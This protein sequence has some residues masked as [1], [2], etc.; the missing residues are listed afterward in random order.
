MDRP[1]S[2]KVQLSYIFS[3]RAY[4]KSVLFAKGLIYYTLPFVTH[5][6][7]RD[8]VVL[9]VG[10]EEL[11]DVEDDGKDDDRDHI[12]GHSSQTRVLVVH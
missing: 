3:T 1:D 12:L 8:D 2:Y 4:L 7:S 5:V 10:L 6:L 9:D 11:W